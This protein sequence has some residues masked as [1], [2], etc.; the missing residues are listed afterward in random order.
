MQK[1]AAATGRIIR[2]LYPKAFQVL[3]IA[4]SRTS[5]A[6]LAV[7]LR[8][9]DILLFP[10]WFNSPASRFLES[11]T[12]GSDHPAPPAGFTGTKPSRD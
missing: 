3:A 10:A 1:G 12:G 4:D 9:G 8:T 5:D 7:A 2:W 11:L 6:D